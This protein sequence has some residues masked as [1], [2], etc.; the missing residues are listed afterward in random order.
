MGLALDRGEVWGLFFSDG[1]GD[2][3][4][5][6]EEGNRDETV[7]PKGDRE[8]SSIEFQDLASNLTPT[9]IELDCPCAIGCLQKKESRYSVLPF[10]LDFLIFCKAT[11]LP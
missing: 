3:G 2:G 9:H 5:W 6:W 1:G 7:Y 8:A 4:D 10:H 11:E